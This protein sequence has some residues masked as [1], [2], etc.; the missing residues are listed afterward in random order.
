MY[1]LMY[2]LC[3]YVFLYNFTYCTY[4]C[5]S[6]FFVCIYLCVYARMHIGGK[7]LGTI[8]NRNEQYSKRQRGVTSVGQ[9]EVLQGLC[10][11]LDNQ[12][13]V[14]VADHFSFQPL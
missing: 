14:L 6:V 7:P 12:P 3:M 1:V 8:K 5:T 10:V 9:R 4:I 2:V 13:Q 11:A